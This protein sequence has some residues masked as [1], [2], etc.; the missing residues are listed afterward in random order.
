[1]RMRR[2][3]SFRCVQEGIVHWEMNMNEN[4]KNNHSMSCACK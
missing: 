1:M 2:E 3:K 4:E